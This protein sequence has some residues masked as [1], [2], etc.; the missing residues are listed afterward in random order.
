M[1]GFPYYHPTDKNIPNVLHLKMKDLT[2]YELGF[3]THAD[4]VQGDVDVRTIPQVNNNTIKFKN[5]IGDLIIWHCPIKPT[6][7][8]PV[9][10]IVTFT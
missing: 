9:E 5:Y 1:E 8:K 10:Q 3:K 6:T 7:G 2:E 4:P